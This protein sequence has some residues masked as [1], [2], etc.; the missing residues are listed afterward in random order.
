MTQKGKSNYDAPTISSSDNN[1]QTSVN[2]TGRE[3][4][5]NTLVNPFRSLSKVIW[6][7]SLVIS[8][9]TNPVQ[10][11]AVSAAQPA[12]IRGNRLNPEVSSELAAAERRRSQA[13]STQILSVGRDGSG[14]RINQTKAMPFGSQH[15]AHAYRRCHRRGDSDRSEDWIFLRYRGI[16]FNGGAQD[17]AYAI[18]VVVHLV[19]PSQEGVHELIGDLE[20]LRWFGLC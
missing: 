19:Q 7:S 10:C 3:G 12:C 18:Q 17:V 9:G 2:P 16:G 5:H 4:I 11:A 13:A 6:L 15:Q 14:S 8:I 1:C 20:V